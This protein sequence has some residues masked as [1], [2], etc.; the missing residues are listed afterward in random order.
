MSL[1]NTFQGM[2]SWTQLLFLCLFAFFGLIVSILIVGVIGLVAALKSGD[3]TNVGALAESI[4]YLRLSQFLSTI[5]IFLMPALLCAYLFNNKTT[6]YLKLNKPVDVKYVLISIGLVFIIQPIISFTAYYN[7]QMKLPSFMSGIE[8]WMLG[9]EQSSAAMM[10]RL[11]AGD[12]MSTLFINIIIIAVMA[13]LTEELFFRGAMQ[14]IFNKITNN[15]HISVW[16]TAF[17]FSAIHMQFYGFIP[18]LLL[19]ALLGYLFVWSRTIWIPI[20]VHFLNNASAV[21]IYWLYHGKPEYEKIENIGVADSWWTILPSVVLT[22]IILLF[23][24]KEYNQ[25]HKYAEL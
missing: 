20:L 7:E 9:M 22:V 5:F 15:Y 4:N 14:Q 17:I 24:L 16:I 18:R 25:K 6:N 21:V 11:M 13:A 1:R 3:V 10:E 12:T 19:G 8:K 23:L 2:S